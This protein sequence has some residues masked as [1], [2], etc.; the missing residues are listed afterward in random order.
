MLGLLSKFFVSLFF[1]S[2]CLLI[3]AD[4]ESSF[5]NTHRRDP[6]IAPEWFDNSTEAGETVL[7]QII[8]KVK[9]MGVVVD[10]PKKYV[11]I[12]DTIVAEKSNWQDLIIDNIEPDH[13][14]VIYRDIKTTIPYKRG[15]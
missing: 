13:I 3:W 15:T 14:D 5:D 4:E 2:I 12:N 10:G 6:F 7:Q 11:I 8:S 9:I 1:L